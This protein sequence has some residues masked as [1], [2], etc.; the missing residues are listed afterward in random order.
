M[1]N[2]LADLKKGDHI[3]YG[4]SSLMGYVIGIK[5]WAPVSHIEIYTGNGKSFASRDGKGVNEYPLRTSDIRYVL[6]PKDE[7]YNFE[8]ASEWFYNIAQGQKYDWKGLLCFTLAVKQ[9]SQDRMFCSEFATRFDREALIKPF[10]DEWDADKIAPG[11]FL[12]SPSFLW[13]Y[14]Y[15]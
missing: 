15:E 13:V 2:P 1:N 10:A 7:F 5:T 3:L 6:R 4:P 14:S 11:N 8:R 12:M 9:G